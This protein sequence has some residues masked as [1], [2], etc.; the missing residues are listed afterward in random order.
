MSEV[1][2]L[3]DEDRLQRFF[4]LASERQQE[5]KESENN[6][7]N[8]DFAQ[9]YRGGFERIKSLILKNPSN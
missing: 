8:K 3:S 9:V 6:K 7:K 2:V 1:Q 4:D 5:Q